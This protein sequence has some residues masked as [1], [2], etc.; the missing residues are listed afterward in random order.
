MPL[1]V[2]YLDDEPELVEIFKD[3]YSS[4]DFEITGFT[5]PDQAVKIIQE[6]PPDVLFIDYRLPNTTGDRIAQKIDS[7]I[8]KALITGD[9]FLQPITHFDIIFKKPYD[10]DEIISF[11]NKIKEKLKI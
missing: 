5:Q 11:L 6:N 1:K 4:K 10:D 9:L 2:Y 8:P 3:S 7:T